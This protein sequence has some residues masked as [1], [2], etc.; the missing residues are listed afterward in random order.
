MARAAASRLLLRMTH[1]E[2]EA[3]PP[4]PAPRPAT[5]VPAFCAPRP[6]APPDVSPPGG[7]FAEPVLI[8][9]AAEDGCSIEY[10]TDEDEGAEWCVYRK[11]I[12]LDG[13]GDLVLRARARA[14]SGLLS[15]AAVCRFESSRV[16][17]VLPKEVITGVL[18]VLSVAAES[19]QQKKAAV[20]RALSSAL[21]APV[22]VLRVDGEG[23]RSEVHFAADAETRAAGRA[24]EKALRQESF[25]AKVANFFGREK[26][27]VAA[28]ALRVE[29]VSRRALETVDLHLDWTFPPGVESDFLDGSCL[30]YEA[31]RCAA[32]VDYCHQ[33]AHPALSHSGDVMRPGGGRHEL[34]VNLDQVGAAVT[35]LYFVLS[36]FHCRDLSRF[37]NP[38]VRLFDPYTPEAQ[39]TEYVHGG[40]SASALVMAA[41]QRRGESWRVLAVGAPCPG[42]VRDYTPIQE[43]IAPM[44]VHYEH[45]ARRFWLVRLHALSAQGRVV[46]RARAAREA[47]LLERVFDETPDDVFRR[48]V[49]FL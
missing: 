48:V 1:A 26:I 3:L 34:R 18:R 43:A 44:Q 29:K 11:P 19:L 2:P 16:L 23:D 21:S 25:T 7:R 4:L 49:R 9:L 8:S 40:T 10:L 20:G 37:P 5:P 33:A 12:L 36:A 24:A 41:L 35:E 38:S 22:R 42:T 27:K 45:A 39:L 31:A 28:A 6:P 13:T 15:E 17:G 14:A 47:Q 46:T 32:A 30:V